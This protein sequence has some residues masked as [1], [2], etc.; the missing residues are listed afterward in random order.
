M[1]TRIITLSLGL[2]FTAAYAG[3]PG[4]RCTGLRWSK[5]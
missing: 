5:A 2:L 3:S 4:A 1:N